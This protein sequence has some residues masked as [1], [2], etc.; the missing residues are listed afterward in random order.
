MKRIFRF[1]KA[2]WRYILHGKRVPF[3]VFVSRLMACENCPNLKRDNWT[4]GICGCYLD[5]KAKMTTEKC[6]DNKW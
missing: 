3:E 5:K 2:L 1:L 6:P 4:C